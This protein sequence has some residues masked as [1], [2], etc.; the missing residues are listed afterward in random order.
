VTRKHWIDPSQDR[1]LHG[2]I[3]VVRLDSGEQR[4]ARWVEFYQ[5][6]PG[7]YADRNGDGIDGLDRI[8]AVRKWNG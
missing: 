3:R 1:P 7:W 4:A 8:E 5:G 6:R 2:E